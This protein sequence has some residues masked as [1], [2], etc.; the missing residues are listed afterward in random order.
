MSEDRTKKIRDARSFEERVF[1]R[2]DSVDE[3]F[4]RVE[5][6][7]TTVEIKI[8]NLEAKQYDTKPIWEQALAQI[9][10]TNRTIQELRSEFQT[11]IEGLRNDLRT[12][13]QTGI[14]GLR[15]DLRTE[16]QTGI[17]GLR[18]DLRTEFQTGIEGLRTEMK[19]EFAAVRHEMEHGLRGV[20]RTID[21]LNQNCLQIQTDQR[22]LD[23]RL[24]YLE[25]QIKST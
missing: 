8:T 7:L 20:A 22:Y 21:T 6:R 4:D 2:F 12:E 3:R 1:A 25:T 18:N 11:G 19:S 10:E 15:N 13:F 5:G 17:E 24:E 23:R 16:F 14:E 9:A